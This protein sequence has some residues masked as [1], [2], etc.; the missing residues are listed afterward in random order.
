MCLQEEEEEEAS[1]LDWQHEPLLEVWVGSTVMGT[2]LE[3]G[4]K[5]ESLRP[6]I[7]LCDTML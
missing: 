5:S 7:C 4:E 3:A 2:T 6:D 1:Q